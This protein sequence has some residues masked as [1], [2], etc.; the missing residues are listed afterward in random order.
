LVLQGQWCFCPCEFPVDGDFVAVDSLI[1]S[2]GL[3]GQL[4]DIWDSALTEALS[5]EDADFNFGLVAL[6]VSSRHL[7]DWIEGKS[8]WGLRPELAE[9]FVGR[10]G[11]EPLGEV[12]GSEEVCQVR[13]DS[14]MGVVEVS[15]DRG[16]LDGAVHPLD[17]P[18]RPGMVGSG[19]P[20]FD[21]MNETEP[22][23]GMAAEACGWPL[24][25]LRQVGEL[26]TVI[27]EHGVDA[28]WN[29][30]EECFEERGGGGPT[31][32]CSLD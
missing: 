7:M 12:V 31:P 11:L 30:L 27:G 25:V 15:L 28:I 8:V 1:P 20:V 26:D 21:S 2:V 22:V 19:Q 18:V 9:V 23:E 5:C 13:F 14:V 24:A 10:E 17:L 6:G 29:G 3:L 32:S 4:V 16:V